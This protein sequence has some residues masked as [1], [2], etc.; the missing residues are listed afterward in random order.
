MP[1]E[2]LWIRAEMETLQVRRRCKTSGVPRSW[3]SKRLAVVVHHLRDV[4]RVLL[5]LQ[6]CFDELDSQSDFQMPFD[7]A[8]N[9]KVRILNTRTRRKQTKDA[10]WKNQT[11][12]LSATSRSVA[13]C[14]DGICT[15]SLRM[16]LS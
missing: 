1:S 5:C 2:F 6:G 8:L 3:L 16:G 13:E 7:V 11:P 10:Q 14:I 4:S 12:G 9:D 15:V